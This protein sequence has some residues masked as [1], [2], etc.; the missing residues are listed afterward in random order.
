MASDEARKKALQIAA[1]AAEAKAGD[2]VIL[3]LQGLTSILDY[4]VIGTGYSVT[5]LQAIMEN[6]HKTMRAQG[7]RPLHC[8]G[9]QQSRW[10]LM[11]FGDVVAHLFDEEARAYY[12]LEQ[13]WADAERV[14]WPES[15]LD[16]VPLSAPAR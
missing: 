1:A 16:R 10:I 12:D 9:H 13:L 11:D 7:H 5:Q 3:N 2:L 6:I 8:E 15:A 4:F 14:A